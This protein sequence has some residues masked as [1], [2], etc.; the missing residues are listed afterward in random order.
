[1]AVRLVFGHG[2]FDTF[3]HHEPAVTGDAHFRDVYAVN[4]NRLSRPLCAAAKRRY[5]LEHDHAQ[6][7]EGNEAGEHT[8]RLRD[9][10]TEP[11]TVEQAHDLA[12]GAVPAFAI[13]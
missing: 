12:R 5:D 9:E 13:H 11:A 6:D 4:F 1:M 3:V 8:N 10:L 2:R 7:G